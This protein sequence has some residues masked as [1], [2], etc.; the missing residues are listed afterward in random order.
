MT[1]RETV[2]E[3]L[4]RLVSRMASERDAFR[5]R[6]ELTHAAGITTAI[7]IV[8]AEMARRRGKKRLARGVW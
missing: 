8:Q 5:R 6:D 2:A 1:R 3:M 4:S 7:E